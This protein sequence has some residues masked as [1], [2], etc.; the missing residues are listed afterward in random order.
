MHTQIT[1]LDAAQAEEQIKTRQ[2][3][4][5]YDVKDFPI[6][7]IVDKYKDGL[8][9]IPRYQ[10]ESVWKEQTKCR[11]IE[12]VILGLPIPMMFLADMDEG[13]LEIV[14]GA[15]RIRAL[16][17]FTNGDLLLKNLKEL[18]RLNGFRFSDL[19]ASQQRK[20][21]TKALRLIILSDTTTE[22]LRQEIFSRINTGGKRATAPEVRR[23]KQQGPFMDF[24]TACAR[25]KNFK[26]VCPVSPEALN[27]REDEELVI[28]FFAYSESYLD[29]KH[30]VDKFLDD[31]AESKRAGFDKER[32]QSEFDA[33]VLFAARFFPHGFA[34]SETAKATPRVRF[35]ALAVGTNLALR[36]RPNLR[37]ASV[38]EW[39]SSKEFVEHTTTH[40]SNS[41]K[42]LRGRIEFVKNALIGSDKG[43]GQ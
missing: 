31:Y 27:R 19:P 25:S 36:E 24:V 16:E 33:T 26:D 13:L 1:P 35:E 3:D 7:Y 20:F 2:H 21:R 8:L 6:D 40:A 11:F 4:V 10:R 29:F 42:R 30:D 38:D 39:L 9:Y 32:L 17:S 37:P 12:S 15:Q 28:R 14:D 5:R 18:P 34:K 22:A 41:S 23:G 43:Q